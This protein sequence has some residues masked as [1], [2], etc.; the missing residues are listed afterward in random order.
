MR[1]LWMKSQGVFSCLFQFPGVGGGFLAKDT[2]ILWMENNYL[3]SF[4][5][6]PSAPTSSQVFHQHPLFPPAL[7]VTGG[8]RSAGS[9]VGAR[10]R[11]KDL[12][13]TWGSVCSSTVSK[14]LKVAIT[15]M[16]GMWASTL[17]GLDRRSPQLYLRKWQSGV[18]QPLSLSL[19]FSASLFKAPT[20]T[21]S[22]PFLF[23]SDNYFPLCRKSLFPYLL[24]SQA[25]NLS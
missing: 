20:T 5:Q 19:H 25:Y 14:A 21:T 16:P 24:G 1:L 7:V 3:L 23:K 10:I 18:H 8:W 11:V 13:S 15:A 12:Q 22:L 17:P 4:L 2:A 6:P 9:G